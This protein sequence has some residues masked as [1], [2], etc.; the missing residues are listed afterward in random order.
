MTSNMARKDPKNTTR[1]WTPSG[2]RG[3]SLMV[4]DFTTHEFPPH[5]HAAFVVAVTESGGSEV[6]SRGDISQADPR[7]LFVFNPDEPHAGWMGRSSHW[8]YRSFYV[9]KPAMRALAD[10]L[11]LQE[12]PYFLRNRFTD[13]D[14]IDA[15]LRLHRSFEDNADGMGS[16]QLMIETFT[17]L[18]ARHG[19]GHH[20]VCSNAWDHRRVGLVIDVMRARFADPLTLSDLSRPLGISSYHLIELFKRTVGLTPHSY[21]TQV[22]LSAA[23]SLL[24]RGVPIAEV[25]AQCGFYDQSALTKHFKRCYALTPL[26]F[27]QAFA[28]RERP[29]SAPQFSPIRLGSG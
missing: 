26:Q 2:I 15:F 29:A 20:P 11:G 23:C 27:A 28:G 5:T 25:A 9:A 21:L 12:L 24:K 14:L 22:R 7:S 1:Y 4:A 10:D 8:G 13:R 3:L 19:C 16:R 17:Q 18:F 6:K